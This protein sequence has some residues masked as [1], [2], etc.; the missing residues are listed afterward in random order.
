MPSAVSAALFDDSSRDD[1]PAL[2]PAPADAP[3]AER[4]R[5]RT[6]EEVVGQSHLLGEGKLLRRVLEGEVRQSLVLWGPPGV[7]KTTIARLV[8][9]ASEARFV[10]FSAVLSGIKEVRAV[11]AEARERRA[12]SGARTLLFVDEIHRFNKA[13][14]DAFLPFVERGDVLLIGA[15]TENPSFELNAAL[16]S[17][18]RVLVL[19]P[20]SVEET[21]E[22]LRGACADERGLAGRLTLEDGQL[23]RIAHQSDG[24]ARRALTL[25]ETAAGARLADGTIDDD[26]LAEAL[27][28]KSVRYDRSGEQHYDLISALHKSVRNS[29][30]NASLYWL[31]RMLEGGEDRRYL[32]RRIVRIASEDVGLADPFALRIALDAA[33][34]FDRLGEPEGDLALAQATVY[35]AR[36]TK[37]NAVYRALAAAREDVQRTANE[38]VPLHLRNAPTRL[39]KESGYG[40]GYRYVHDD[41]AAKDEMDCLPP[42]LRG[43]DY[44]ARDADRE[45]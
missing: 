44:F 30:E 18:C 36:A 12:R 4:M 24:D 6:P 8:A 27:Q 45:R 39:M 19:E 20:L 29:D 5:P 15:T 14:Q 33:E 22:L 40:A 42:S 13:Q 25:L 1:E 38:P 3:L 34:S 43:R 35:L 17:R 9:D 23:A 31:A 7:G 26:A 28:R 11:M 10:P 32:A 21:V 16:L 37:S 2:D 41:P